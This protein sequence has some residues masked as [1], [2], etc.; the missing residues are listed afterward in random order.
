MAGYIS[1]LRRWISFFFFLIFAPSSNCWYVSI[2]GTSLSTSCFVFFFFLLVYLAL[3][4]SVVFPLQSFHDWFT[5]DFS[6]CVF[7]CSRSSRLA[8]LSQTTSAWHVTSASSRPPSITFYI[9]HTHTHT[10]IKWLCNCVAPSID[11]L[12]GSCWK[13]KNKKIAT[14]RLLVNRTLKNDGPTPNTSI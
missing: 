3:C 9:P 2:P 8:L 7:Y 1:A 4:C 13:K 12:P 5:Q 14:A 11:L 6:L 10:N